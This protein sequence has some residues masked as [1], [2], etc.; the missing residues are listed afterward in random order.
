MSKIKTYLK[1]LYKAFV[2][3]FSSVKLAI[4]LFIFLAITTLIGTVL[5][6]E[7][8]VGTA[9]M[10]K[11]YGLEKYRLLK[12]LG[13]TDVFHSW[14]Y[15]A[16]LTALGI[17]L[18]VASFKRVFPKWR[19]AFAWP[20]EITEEANIKKLP[21]NCELSLN[22]G[23]GIN[24]LEK[25]L[26]QNKY[27]TKI[28]NNNLVAVKGGWHRLGASVT[29]VGILTLLIGC[30]ISTLTG[31]NGMAQVG[32][33]E[34]FYLTDLG[35]KS[36]QIRSIEPENWLTPISKMP[37]WLGRIPRY[38]VKVNKTWRVD[39]ESGQ[40]KQWYSDLSV[41][42]QKKKELFRK[43]IHVNEPLEFMGLDIYQSNWGKFSQISFNNEPITLPLENFRGEDVVILPLG[44]DVGLKLVPRIS[45][46]VN[47]NSSDDTR[48]TI[49]DILELYSISSDGSKQK[50]LGKVE[51]DKKL[52]LGPMSIGYFGTQTLT[53]LQF[54]SNPGS[55]LIYPGLFFIILG[56]FI[57]FGSRK[58]IWAL[59]SETNN[60]IVIGGNADRAKGKFFQEFEELISKL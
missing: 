5:P 41:L 15:L 60:K 57:A 45:S 3:E 24:T 47:R 38:L 48:Y 43:T 49:H 51:K 37:L 36:V 35:D 10:V 46:S 27:K 6:E 19:I 14:W 23:F 58:Q 55:V 17:N 16:L 21:I 25:K 54:K 52:Q 4:T 18:I 11:K 26:K 22:N 20:V 13:L 30:A 7:P 33:S 56:V 29:H 44:K 1:N 59:V 8:M 2:E 42:D 40:P 32:E 34:G 12:S 53:G 50:Y 39:Y 28:N 9:E 31:F